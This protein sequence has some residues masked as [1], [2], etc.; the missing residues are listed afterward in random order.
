MSARDNILARLR[1]H[2]PFDDYPRHDERL[3]VAPVSPDIDLIALFIEKATALSAHVY[4]TQTHEQAIQHLLTLIGDDKKILAWDFEH[5]PID[6]LAHILRLQ[7]IHVADATDATVRVGVTGADAVLATTGSLI[8]STQAGKPRQPSLLPP[9]HIAVIQREQIIPHLEAWIDQ[10]CQDLEGFRTI[11]NHIIIT[12]ASR[13]A[14]IAMELVLGAH[15]P[16][17][18]HIIMI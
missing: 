10:Q 13:T 2:T 15:G 4:Q 9:V 5:I 18:L 12:G 8:V 16:A 7:G 6:N 1:K 17:Q 11:G 3:T 14:D